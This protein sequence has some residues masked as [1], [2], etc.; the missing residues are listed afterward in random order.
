MALLPKLLLAAVIGVQEFL[1]RQVSTVWRQ[2]L[3]LQVE[4]ACN[5]PNHADFERAMDKLENNLST[6][7]DIYFA[8][9]RTSPP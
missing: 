5:H 2:H 7:L 4:I 1:L 8:P 3:K 9:Q 6:K